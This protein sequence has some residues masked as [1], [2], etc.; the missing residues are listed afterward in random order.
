MGL[1]KST[2]NM[3]PFMKKCIIILT[4]REYFDIIVT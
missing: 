1:N 3:Y 4:Q 2:G